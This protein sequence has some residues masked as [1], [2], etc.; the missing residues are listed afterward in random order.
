MLQTKPDDGSTHWSTRTIAKETGVSK[1]T[2][3][4][5]L[6]AFSEKPHLQKTPK[7]S[8][9]PFFVEK[10]RDIVGLYLNPPDKAVVLCV[11]E[12][13]QIQ[14]WTEHSPFCR[15]D[16]AILKVLPMTTFVMVQRHCSL[17]YAYPVEKLLLNADRFTAI[18]SF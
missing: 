15:W 8:T 12:R 10:V 1:T 4:R 14:H 2:V 16:W 9:D 18:K 17:L 3:H 5:W 13:S 6:Q 7:L 11:D